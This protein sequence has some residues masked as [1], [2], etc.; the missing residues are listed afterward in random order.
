MLLLQ[1][2]VQQQVCLAAYRHLGSAGDRFQPVHSAVL[3]FCTN[4]LQGFKNSLKLFLC[5]PI[6]KGADCSH[7]WR[8][9]RN[10]KECSG[11]GWAGL[12]APWTGGRSMA[13]WDEIS[14]K[15]CSN[16][17]QS[18][19]LWSGSTASGF[20]Y[21]SIIPPSAAQLEEARGG[22]SSFEL[23]KQSSVPGKPGWDVAQSP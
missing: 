2:P 22:F 14:F 4:I 9:R 12:W 19:I 10:G 8:S 5:V 3:P 23:N 18:V 17:N 11:L 20:G 6:S 13:G 16:P 1:Y 7:K 21:F 15:V